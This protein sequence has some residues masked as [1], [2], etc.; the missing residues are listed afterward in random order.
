MDNGHKNVQILYDG[1]T[2]LRYLR[3]DERRQ[4]IVHKRVS[5]NIALDIGEHEKIVG[6][7]ILDVSRHVNLNIT[8]PAVRSVFLRQNHV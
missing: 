3:L 6:S 7:E 1:K 5:G 4:P 8:A 2:D